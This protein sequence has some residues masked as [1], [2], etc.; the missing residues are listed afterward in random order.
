MEK[1]CTWNKCGGQREIWLSYLEDATRSLEGCRSVCTKDKKPGC[2]GR[3]QPVE[4]QGSAPVLLIWAYSHVSSLTLPRHWGS[5]SPFTPWLTSPCG[6]VSS[7]ISQE[8]A[9][10]ARISAPA[11]ITDQGRQ[12]PSPYRADVLGSR[13]GQQAVTNKHKY[14]PNSTSWSCQGHTPVMGHGA[15]RRWMQGCRRDA[16]HH[17]WGVAQNAEWYGRA[18]Q[19]WGEGRELSS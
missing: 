2:D 18:L 14:E 6:L 19:R 1:Y 15:G 8:A 17:W 5:S 16:T 10:P 4:G 13:A 9:C 3:T 11:H 7:F 12:V